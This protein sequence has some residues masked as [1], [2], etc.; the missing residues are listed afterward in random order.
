MRRPSGDQLGSIPDAVVQTTRR[1]TLRGDDHQLASL[2]GIPRP[3]F[4]RHGRVDDMRAVR[5]PCWIEPDGRQPSDPLTSAPHHEESTAAAT[6]SKHDP[7]P[8]RRER[9]LVV[10]VSGIGGEIDRRLAANALK[11]HVAI[12]VALTGVHNPLPVWR[13][14]R[15]QLGARP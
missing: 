1:A 7:F 6:G 2:L 11:I 8:V 13:E 12:P 5:R 14:T 9:R 10:V 3:D 4:S 15:K